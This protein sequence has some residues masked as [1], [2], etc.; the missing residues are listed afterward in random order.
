MSGRGRGRG[1]RGGRGGRGDGIGRGSNYQATTTKQKGACAEL[2]SHVFDYG[3][4]GCA[5]QMKTTYEAICG[6]VGTKYGNDIRTELVNRT[7]FIIE[8][9]EHSAA[10]MAVHTSRLANRASNE[11][12]SSDA[13]GKYRQILA[14]TVQSN[15]T[16]AAN[17][18]K[19]AEIENE[20]ENAALA[21]TL[22]MPIQMT[23]EEKVAH[24]NE[25]KVHGVRQSSLTKTRGQAFSIIKGQ[26]TQVMLDKMKYE[27]TWDAIGKHS[28]PLE[29]MDLIEKTIL[30]QEA[31]KKALCSDRV[32]TF[33]LLLKIQHLGFILL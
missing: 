9:P 2:G 8:P 17:I 24:H 5:D 33:I 32:L 26:C 13:R 23:D 22:P 7:K 25:W 18:M 1:S 10:V 14:S 29:L 12:R 27:P 30:A 16:D 4:R 20:I 19:L 3:Q 21:A 11:K 15:P 6:H 28:D 31:G